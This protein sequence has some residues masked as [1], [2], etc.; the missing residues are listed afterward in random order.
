MKNPTLTSYLMHYV[1]QIVRFRAVVPQAPRGLASNA[2]VVALVLL[3]LTA[4]QAGQ[5]N[6]D[7][8]T[9]RIWVWHAW[10]ENEAQVLTEV[11]NLY[12]EL[13]PDTRVIVR[14]AI[15]DDALR[16]FQQ[17][18]LND[19]LSRED[20][21]L[22]EYLEA[23]RRGTGPDLLIGSSDWTRQLAD[24]GLIRDLNQYA[25]LS[26]RD[27]LPGTVETLRYRDRLYGLPLSLETSALF[28]NTKLVDTPAKSFD[29]LLAQAS[30]GINTVIITT[31][32][33]AFW[34]LSAFGAQLFDDQGRLVLDQ[35]GFSD[36]LNWLQT[37]SARPQFYLE[38]DHE[39]HYRLFESGEAA[40]YVGKLE[41]YATLQ[42]KL[43]EDA[44]G[45]SVLPSGP[46]GPAGPLLRTEAMMF[47][48][49]SAPAQ[50]EAALSLAQF[51]AGTGVQ[52]ELSRDDRLDRVPANR[53]VRID[54]RVHPAIAAFRSQARSAI[55][56]PNLPQMDYVWQYGDE[57]YIGVLTG[58][59]APS[60]AA[61]KLTR[62]VNE[63]SGY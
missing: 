35:G 6:S 54:A 22:A 7:V 17:E 12:S 46:A 42:Q 31:F 41:E 53:W 47:N 45:I 39:G 19:A 36:W 16:A 50:T 10:D 14:P 51:L 56:V 3:L 24:A 62:Q 28:Y 5:T 9:N 40:Y 33:D 30:E 21:L 25:D 13:H 20:L 37:A 23:A 48:S 4:C 26:T 11:V 15:S 18:R 57:A 8:I 49:Y 55:P 61:T 27:F 29:D 1:N 2:V 52:N 59:T 44:V 38:N 34:G 58:I 43:G 32:D 60:E 63:A